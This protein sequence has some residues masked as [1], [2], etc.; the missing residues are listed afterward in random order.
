MNIHTYGADARLA[1]CK[2]Y[3]RGENIHSV[4][5]IILLPIPTTKDG[6][7]LHGSRQN[8]SEIADK[9]TR[10]DVFVGYGLPKEFRREISSRGAA[11]IDVS[12]DEEYLTENANLTAV[13]TVG[14]ILSEEKAAPSELS[15]GVIGYGR[16]GQRL[17]RLLMFLSGRVTVF[18]SKSELRQELCMLGISGADSL[19]VDSSV[20]AEKLAALDIL[21]NTAPAKLLGEN[22]REALS[23][24]R[25]IELA[26]GDNMP[27][28]VAVERFVSV[29]AVMYPKSA[30]Y[31]LASSILRMLGEGT[32][33][34]Q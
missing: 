24:V 3:L 16:I 2:E 25:V 12:R 14:R 31:A 20:T 7:T 6:E 19:S 34:Y 26:S 21:I 18:T 13:G 1:F 15:V 22:S 33:K 29:P 9:C 28:G 10:G 11:A 5:S 4:G 8:L 32:D 17:V 30:G 23:K 27:E